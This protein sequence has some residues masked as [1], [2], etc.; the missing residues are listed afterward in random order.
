MSGEID[1]VE[2]VE[3]GN[4]GG[5]VTLHTKNSCTMGGVKRHQ[6][7]GV[8]KDNCWNGTDDNAGCGVQG[9]PETYGQKFNDNGGGVRILIAVHSCQSLINTRFMPWS[10][11]MRAS[12]YGSSI[13]RTFQVMS[14]LVT[15]L[16]P[17][18]ALGACPWQTSQGPTAPS[19][20]I[21]PIKVRLEIPSL[22]KQ[23]D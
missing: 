14:P 4:T 7:G 19:A 22:L 8:L 11:A 20:S 10:F 6:Y 15:T 18:Q 2:A 21:A 16:H 23:S 1:I 5:Q 17:I 12:A 3:Q 13:A 9:A